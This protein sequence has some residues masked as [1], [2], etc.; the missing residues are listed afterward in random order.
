MATTADSVRSRT[1]SSTK[2]REGYA[3]GEVDGFLDE[4]VAALRHHGD[5]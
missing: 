3:R 5:G 4:V 2:W 1:F